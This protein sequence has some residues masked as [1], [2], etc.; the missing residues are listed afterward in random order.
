MIP[1]HA[2]IQEQAEYAQKLADVFERHF[3]RSLPHEDEF[4]WGDVLPLRAIAAT[5]RNVS[6]AQPTNN[7]S[8]KYQI[9]C[10]EIHPDVTADGSQVPIAKTID[11]YTQI[12]PDGQ[13]NLP[14]FIKALNPTTRKRRAKKEASA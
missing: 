12:I 11:V 14:A 1:P 2:T 3:A 4:P 6:L 13:F 9:T 5:L 7:M 8:L 10:T